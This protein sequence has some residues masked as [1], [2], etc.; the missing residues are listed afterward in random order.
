MVTF[1]AFLLSGWHRGFRSR[2]HWQVGLNSSLPTGLWSHYTQANLLPRYHV[3]LPCYTA[4]PYLSLFVEKFVM[5]GRSQT[6]QR[7][8]LHSLVASQQPGCIK[9]CIL[10]LPHWCCI[11]AEHWDATMVLPCSSAAQS[12]YNDSHN[13]KFANCATH[14]GKAVMLKLCVCV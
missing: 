4:T 8:N 10:S 12:S 11:N 6:L 1:F 3:M 14:T 13:D 9:A 2:T 7:C 5:L